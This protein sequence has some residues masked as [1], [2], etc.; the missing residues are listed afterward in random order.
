MDQMCESM[1]KNRYKAQVSDEQATYREVHIH[2]GCGSPCG[3][4]QTVFRRALPSLCMK[5]EREGRRE[6]QIRMEEPCDTQ[7][8][9]Q[10]QYG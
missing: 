1:D 4:V 9:D 7:P 2:Q 5:D 6:E 8:A 3:I 10:P